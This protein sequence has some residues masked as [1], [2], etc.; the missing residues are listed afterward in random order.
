MSIPAKKRSE[1]FNTLLTGIVL[2]MALPV[3]VYFIVYFTTIRDIKSVLFSNIRIVGNIIPII[4]S[5]CI[6]P[7][8]VLFFVFIAINWLHAAK[9]VLTSAVVLTLVLFGLKLILTLI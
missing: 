8:L 9:G 1:R 4:L 2:G 5:H 6:L 3:L 7:N